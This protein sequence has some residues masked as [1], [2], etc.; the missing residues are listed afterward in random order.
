MRLRR[1]DHSMKK[2]SQILLT[3]MGGAAVGVS[4]YAIFMKMSQG[5]LKPNKNKKEAPQL[6]PD[7]EK[8]S[9]SAKAFAERR[10]K[11]AMAIRAAR[12]EGEKKG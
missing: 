5:D 1:K 8:I 3:L 2:K 10:R 7:R 9:A 11:R 4:I 12:A 6:L